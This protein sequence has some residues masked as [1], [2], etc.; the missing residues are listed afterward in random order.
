MTERTD[1]RSQRN[2]LTGESF[3]LKCSLLP[4]SEQSNI[5]KKIRDNY[6][7]NLPL[8]YIFLTKEERITVRVRLVNKIRRQRSV[9]NFV[10]TLIWRQNLNIL[11]TYTIFLLKFECKLHNDMY[12]YLGTY[13]IFT[14]KILRSVVIKLVTTKISYNLPHSEAP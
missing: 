2:I 1:V 5:L 9:G 10:A 14:S 12:M 13:L 3:N 11:V 4:K 8:A 6:N 7:L